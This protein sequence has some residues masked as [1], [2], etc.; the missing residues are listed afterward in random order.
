M[1]AS[2]WNGT[3]ASLVDLHGLLPK[4][5]FQMSFAMGVSHDARYTYIV[6]WGYNL[7]TKRDEAL[8]WRRRR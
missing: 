2:M 6:G 8:M 3:A 4:N 1:R 7:K 5:T